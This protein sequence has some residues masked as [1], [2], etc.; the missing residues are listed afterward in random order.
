MRRWLPKICLWGFELPKICLWGFELPKICLWGFE[1]PK[2][3]FLLLVSWA[4]PVEGSTLESF[5]ENTKSS[6]FCGNYKINDLKSFGLNG[7]DKIIKT[8]RKWRHNQYKLIFTTQSS[9]KLIDGTKTRKVKVWFFAFVYWFFDSSST[10]NVMLMDLTWAGCV[11]EKITSS[12]FQ[13]SQIWCRWALGRWWCCCS[14]PRCC[15][16]FAGNAAEN[17]M[18]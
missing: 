6:R 3:A 12:P 11:T 5:P 18:M 1:L 4:S 15:S 14:L 16:K 8:D 13:S 7:N 10:S 2:I 9:D 17:T